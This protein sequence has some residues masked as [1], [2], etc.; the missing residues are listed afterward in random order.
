M[1]VA[2][3]AFLAAGLQAILAKG[4]LLDV[5][6]LYNYPLARPFT[7]FLFHY[8]SV[9]VILVFKSSLSTLCPTAVCNYL[10]QLGIW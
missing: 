7:Y 5:E 9:A 2:V 8:S 3:L 10:K 4:L 6:I 1:K